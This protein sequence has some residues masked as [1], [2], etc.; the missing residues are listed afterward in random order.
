MIDAFYTE[1]VNWWVIAAYEILQAPDQMEWASSIEQN[2]QSFSGPDR[3]ET[4]WT[5]LQRW[6]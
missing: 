2:F 4:V 3:Y 5:D 6:K 1:M